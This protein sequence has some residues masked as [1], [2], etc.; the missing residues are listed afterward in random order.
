MKEDSEDV[1]LLTYRDL[2]EDGNSNRAHTSLRKEFDNIIRYKLGKDISLDNF[3]SVD[4]EDTTLYDKYENNTTDPEGV[5]VEKTKDN[6]DPVMATGLDREV[7]TPEANDKYVNALV[8]LPRGDSYARG[9]VIGRKRDTYENAV[10]RT[11][12]K[13]I[14]ETRKYRVD[15]YDGEVSELTENMIVESMYAAC[16]DS[17]NE[18]LMMESIVDYRNSDKDISVCNQK[19]VHRGWRFMRQSTVG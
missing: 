16:D 6:E 11:N 14:L 18:Y 4:L 7:P 1:H 8:M 10:V 5:L 15:F 9:K 13:P 2:K 17:G 19:M 3:P 12:D